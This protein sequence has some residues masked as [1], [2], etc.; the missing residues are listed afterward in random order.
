MTRYG[1]SQRQRARK[2]ARTLSNLHSP[3]E[4]QSPC[5]ESNVPSESVGVD[6]S[7]GQNRV[8][9]DDQNLQS[10]INSSQNN[11][12]ASDDNN[13]ILS[14]SAS[15][16][17]PT[18]NDLFKV[19]NTTNADGILAGENTAKSKNNQ[20]ARQSSKAI[21]N[22]V[23]H[24]N[25]MIRGG[26]NVTDKTSGADGNRS[27]SFPLLLKAALERVVRDEELASGRPTKNWV[28]RFK[29]SQKAINPHRRRKYET[30]S[31]KGSVRKRVLK[32]L[33]YKNLGIELSYAEVKRADWKPR[34]H[35][36]VDSRIGNTRK[37]KPGCSNLR[38]CLTEIE[39][40][41][42]DKEISKLNQL[43]AKEENEMREEARSTRVS[44]SIDRTQS[45]RNFLISKSPSLPHQVHVAETPES[46]RTTTESNSSQMPDILGQWGSLETYSRF[47][48]EALQHALKQAL[49]GSQRNDDCKYADQMESTAETGTKDQESE[50]EAAFLKDSDEEDE[51]AEE[52]GDEDW[53]EYFDCEENLID[54]DYFLH[55]RGLREEMSEYINDQAERSSEEDEPQF[56]AH[57][58]SNPLQSLDDQEN[59]HDA[60]LPKST[61][62]NKPS[63]KR[64]SQK[65]Q[66]LSRTWV[67]RFLAKKAKSRRRRMPRGPGRFIYPSSDN[68]LLLLMNGINTNGARPTRGDTELLRHQRHR[69]SGQYVSFSSPLRHCWTYIS[70]EK[71]ASEEEAC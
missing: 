45:P 58:F 68:V 3:N 10:I 32:R 55:D 39:A 50:L 21:T 62:P 63:E 31:P 64:S 41:W 25:T 29:D 43:I 49:T 13:N 48:F 2:E 54:E 59:N 71:E 24:T 17:S 5:N 23:K 69:K 4:V 60:S 11:G 1:F 38:Y 30:K 53:E 57:L 6:E 8:T 66:K 51:G 61:K 20:D 14:R 22:P 33:E 37:P 67:T 9:E 36:T 18:L 52:D 47:N 65:L 70:C 35:M 42:A 16:V 19:E 46:P 28:T 56:A 12:L 40:E 34:N 26:G 27:T 15:P 7:G 44:N